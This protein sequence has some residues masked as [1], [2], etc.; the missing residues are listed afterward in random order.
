MKVLGFTDEERLDVLKKNE[1]A[2]NG[3]YRECRINSFVPNT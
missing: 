2:K 3:T 1:V